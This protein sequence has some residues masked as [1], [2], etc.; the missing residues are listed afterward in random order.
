M[1]INKSNKIL[2]TNSKDWKKFNSKIQIARFNKFNKKLMK[3]IKFWSFFFNS[4]IQHQIKP[5]KKNKISL[6]KF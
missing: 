2:G 1:D 3:L 5:K 4:L 6:I